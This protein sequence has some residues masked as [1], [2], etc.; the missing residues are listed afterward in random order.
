MSFLTLNVKYYYNYIKVLKKNIKN[1]KTYAF[2][3]L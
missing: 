1:V 3:Y 2:I